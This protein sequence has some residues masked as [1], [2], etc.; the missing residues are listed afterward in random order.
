MRCSRACAAPA[1]RRPRRRGSPTTSAPTSCA[2][3]SARPAGGSPATRSGCSWTPSAPTCASSPRPRRSSLSDSGGQVDA[4]AVRAL[5]PGPRRGHGVRG[6]RAGHHGRPDGGARVAALGAGDRRA[7]RA[8]GR[9]P[10]RRRA[11][12]GAGQRRRP[13]RPVRAWRRRSRC[14]RGRCA[15]PRA[16]VRGWGDEGL[17]RAM[18]VVADLNA[19]SRAPPPTRPT[20]WSTPSSRSW[21]PGGARAAERSPRS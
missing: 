11:H 19:T 4:D 14:R 10:R 6:R 9:R 12:R 5:P 1:P 17:T 21:R 20:P 16:R 3:R 8:A 18:G 2:P 13:R 7:A 15:R